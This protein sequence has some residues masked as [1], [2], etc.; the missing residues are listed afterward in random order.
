MLAAVTPVWAAAT[1]FLTEPPPDDPYLRSTE[2]GNVVVRGE[3]TS[4]D[5]IESVRFVF[6]PPL[7]E[8]SERCKS[9]LVGSPNVSIGQDPKMATFELRII[10]PCNRSHRVD[11]TVVHRAPLDAPV[12][13]G[14][15]RP[16]DANASSSF[17]VAVPPAEV[18]GLKAS[19]DEGSKKVSLSWTANSEPD[20]IGYRVERNPPGPDGFMPVG[21]MVSDT[22]F[23]D[24]L[25]VDEE[26]RYRVV[27]VR[28][29]PDASLSRISGEPSSLVTTGPDRPEPTVP[30][31]TIFRPPP[32]AN[33][34]GSGGGGRGGSSGGGG[35][36]RGDAPQIRRGPVTTLDDGFSQNLPFDPSQTTTPLPPTTGTV[37]PEDAAVLA[38]DDDRTEEDDRRATMVPIAGGL[39]LM[40]GAVHLRLLSKRAGAPELPIYRTPGPPR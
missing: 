10:S 18:E 27:A 1:L 19:Y 30:D 24:T 31:T 29:G 32:L 28:S 11:A 22:S 36:S 37:S 4:D 5:P 34:S 12:L 2:D 13:G 3:V 7:E 14:V 38:I 15:T 25:T 8:G 39:A 33:S 9:S 21:G 26:H 16:A 40:M 23:T 6:N 17:G 35:S 20:L